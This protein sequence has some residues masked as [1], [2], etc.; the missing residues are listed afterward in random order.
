[1]SEAKMATELRSHE[2]TGLICGAGEFIY[3]CW[4]SE[5]NARS[6]TK[7]GELGGSA[8]RHHKMAMPDAQH[9]LHLRCLRLGAQSRPFVSSSCPFLE[10]W[11]PSS[12]NAPPRIRSLDTRGA[13]DRRLPYAGG[14]SEDRAGTG[15]VP[16]WPPN[17]DARHVRPNQCTHTRSPDGSDTQTTTRIAVL[18]YDCSRLEAS[19]DSPQVSRSVVFPSPPP[20][21]AAAARPPGAQESPPRAEPACLGATA[22]AAGEPQADTA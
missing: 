19:E 11:P 21:K 22:P 2:K 4:G 12:P 10:G 5:P 7:E 8:R 17:P 6:K 18:A 3:N 9:P 13:W 20:E 14:E 1:M 16:D 15:A